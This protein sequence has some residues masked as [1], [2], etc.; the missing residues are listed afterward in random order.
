VA[1]QLAARFASLDELSGS[2][3][4]VLQAVEGIGPE[5]ATSITG[6]FAEKHNRVNLARL[7]KGG[8]RIVYPE[9]S[10]ADALSLA[11]AGKTLVLTGTLDTMTREEAEE[12]IR[13]R[14]G[15]PTGSVSRK[16]SWVVR[17]SD[18]GSKVAKAEELGV[19]ILDESAFRALLGLDQ[20]TPAVR[21]PKPDS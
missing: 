21:R 10:R 15:R 13:A 9:R 11:L 6:F 1:R 4:D 18:P 20:A 3:P 7:R 19:P 8:V 16:T 5:L 2:P 12:A 14:G 17:G